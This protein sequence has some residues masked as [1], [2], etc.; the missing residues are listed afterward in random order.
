EFLVFS[1]A[2]LSITFLLLGISYLMR[3]F[4][5]MN[6]P[7]HVFNTGFWIAV[8]SLCYSS[9]IVYV[10]WGIIGFTILRRFRSV[11][12]WRYLIG[13]LVPYFWIAVAVFYKGELSQFLQVQ[14]ID[15]LGFADFSMFT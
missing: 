9:V 11:E 4:K 14:F 10:I 13:F 2:V 3:A 7:A 15:N 1:P 8:A 6:A 5:I 12:I